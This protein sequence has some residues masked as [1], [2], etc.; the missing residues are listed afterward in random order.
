MLY[1]Y[2]MVTQSTSD[3][4]VYK[5]TGKLYDEWYSI[6]EQ[7]KA[8]KLS[9]KEIAALLVEE[10]DVSFWWA[11]TITVEYERLIGRREVGQSCEGDFQAGA[12]KTLVG[13]MDNVY[14]RWLSF[15]AEI[16]EL[17]GVPISEEPS[18]SKTEKWR[19][20]RVK[21]ADNS[22]ANIHIHRK[23]A[24]KVQIAVN[25]EQ[26]NDADAVAGWKLFWR[27]YFKEFADNL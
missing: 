9:H 13:T 1:I 5:A 18:L 12:S 2:S 27:A 26:L 21:L 24:G 17:N 7:K 23:A 14:D 10:Y 25:H 8:S 15:V 20:W 3:E 22:K 19:Y 6:L 4:A 16:D 11:Q